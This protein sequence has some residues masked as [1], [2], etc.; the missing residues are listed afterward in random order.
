MH[1]GTGTP[2][3]PEW[4]RHQRADVPQVLCQGASPGE[5]PPALCELLNQRREM[6][7]APREP[8]LLIKGEQAPLFI[9]GFI[10]G[11]SSSPHG[12]G[13]S[14]L[15]PRVLQHGRST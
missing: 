13:D 7:R 2:V 11:S 15:T 5:A 14:G 8:R 1:R 3:G 10:H 6:L 9:W 4:L 12:P